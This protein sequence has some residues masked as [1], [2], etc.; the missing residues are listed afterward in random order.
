MTA[1]RARELAGLPDDRFCVTVWNQETGYQVDGPTN[2][3]REALIEL[4]EI[5]EAAK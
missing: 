1:K 4:A 5:K 3:V 2:E